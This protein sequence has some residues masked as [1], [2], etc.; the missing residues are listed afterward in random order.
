MK[1]NIMQQLKINVFQNSFFY[2]KVVHF[3]KK[4]NDKK[5]AY[6]WPEMPRQIN[7]KCLSIKKYYIK[8]KLHIEKNYLYLLPITIYNKK[9]K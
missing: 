8:I 7:V 9:Q 6:W 5:I 3:K 2:I 4:K 1:K